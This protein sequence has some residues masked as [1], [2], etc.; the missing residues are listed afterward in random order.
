MWNRRD[1]PVHQEWNEDIERIIENTSMKMTR[2][3]S[4]SGRRTIGSQ[5]CLLY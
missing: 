1:Q 4:S 3:Q 5:G 2:D